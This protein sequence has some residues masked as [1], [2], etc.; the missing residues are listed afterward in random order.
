MDLAAPRAWHSR[1]TRYLGGA[2]AWVCALLQ[3]LATKAND[4][5]GEM[6]RAVA[7]SR[8]A[9]EALAGNGEF[10]PALVE[11]AQRLNL[12]PFESDVILL[13]TAFA[14]DSGVPALCAAASGDPAK[15]YPTFA[16]AMRLFDEPAWD[17]VAAFG[18]L[19]HWRLI[20]IHQPPGAPL[21]TSAL[22][23]DERVIDYVKGLNH[24]DDR[25]EGWVSPIRPLSPGPLPM[26][27]V[28]VCDRIEATVRAERERHSVPVIQLF[29]NGSESKRVVA[30]ELSRRIGCHPWRLSAASVSAFGTELETFARLLLR[31]S[32]LLEA[33]LYI[34]CDDSVAAT[35]GTPSPSLARL[36]DRLHGVPIF[37]A[38]RE[39][40]LGFERPSINVHV[41]KPTM[42]EQRS[43]W[44]A[45][46]GHKH[47]AAS[48]LLAG[49]FDLDVVTIERVAARA[50]AAGETA[51]KV[52]ALLWREA[53][54]AV[55]PRV[56]GLAEQI[57]TRADWSDLV[58]AN[59][60]IDL[61][62]ELAAQAKHRWTVY[63]QWGFARRLNRGLG[64]AALFCG[65]SGTGKTMAAEVI[66]RD[67]DLDLYRIDLASVV[68]KY[69]GETEKN[70][71][72]VFDA[73]E[74]GGAILFF[75]EADA[76]FGKRSD[77]KDSHDRYA[78]I[79]INYL[80]QRMEAYRGLVIL[81]TNR[82]SSLDHAFVRRLRFIIEFPYPGAAERTKIW[83]KVFPAD[84]PKEG[85]LD[86][87]RLAQLALSGGN[88]QSVALNAAFRAASENRK[89]GMDLVLSCARAEMTKLARP[90][91]EAD[92]RWDP[93]QARQA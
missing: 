85:D 2:I 16:L 83:Q 50:E 18:P 30:C 28:S 36:I 22:S 19:R 15:P 8:S 27:H 26:S 65:D 52:A 42:S 93:A 69:I 38:T 73:F 91:S 25:I 39:P 32:V 35:E 67:I 90:I 47:N 59:E 70:L 6:D 34:D 86:P 66:A 49:Q 64:I 44:L 72:R 7:A 78:N 12:A 60:Q 17:A 77:V 5:R 62:R 89:V 10:T 14:L 43:V 24:I 48:A 45:L 74:D 9:L 4:R 53:R 20:E 1:N 57:D 41:R 58:L 33:V 51:A 68:S 40:L 80:L 81:A 56:S 21:I 75:D 82:R 23:A 87:V 92:F 88:I 55:R 31:E 76:L 3:A 63:D 46:L 61:L 11:L 79:E 37:L 54:E 13:C 29:G 84:T 71:R